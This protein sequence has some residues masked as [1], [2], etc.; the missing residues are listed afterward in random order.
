LKLLL[1][2]HALIWCV[3]DPS[4]LS[5]HAQQCLRNP[6]NLVY[7]SAVS[8]WE[9]ALKFAIGKLILEGVTPEQLRQTGLDM[10]FMELPLATETA[11]GFYQLSRESHKDPFDRMLVW[12]AVSGGYWLVSKDEGLD[13]YVKQGLKVLW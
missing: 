13:A 8:L 11:A 1:D 3:C 2:S 12:Q 7:F 9:I 4:R 10:G 5:D 6:G